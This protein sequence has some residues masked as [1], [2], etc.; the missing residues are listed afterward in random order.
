ML[1]TS[2]N[3]LF[4][5]LCSSCFILALLSTALNTALPSIA[6]DLGVNNQSVQWLISIYAL[7]LA[8]FMPAT[9]YFVSRFTAR[10]LYAASLILFLLCTL[11]CAF[12]SSFELLLVA[13]IGQAAANALVSNLTQTTILSVFN[14]EEQ[15]SRMGW[16]GLSVGVAP[17]IAPAFGG[18]MVDLFGWR[19]LFLVIAAGAALCLLSSFFFMQNTIDVELAS[20]DIPSFVLSVFVFGGL[21]L[22]LSRLSAGEFLALSSLMPLLCALLAAVCFI[23]CQLC[24]SKPFLNL[25]LFRNQYFTRSVIASSALYAVMM[26]GAAVLPLYLQGDLQWSA[27]LA[28]FVVFPAA[29]AMALVNP[30]A[31]KM[32]NR[33]GIRKLACLSCVFMFAGNILMC[34]L[35]FSSSVP[36]VILLAIF[37]YLGI[38][39]LQMPLV[40]W[41]NSLL[42]K[43]ELPHATAL[44]T[45]F[46]NLFG[47]LG[48]AVFVGIFNSAGLTVG[49]TAMA[50]V[51]LFV[52]I[53]NDN[54]RAEE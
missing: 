31:G 47:A 5:L 41:A 2:K 32:L 34:I 9:A 25:A 38:G 11:L 7:S 21:T 17:V 19:S 22:G 33:L 40:V 27:T 39:L 52:L 14:K 50:F 10:I 35:S 3:A 8:V 26:G 53:A 24:A 23:P 29:L 51:A 42:N 13:R 4:L 1:D 16:F 43:S 28:G 30:F 12:S 54:K 15:G 44:L 36:A 6:F 18:V 46:R 20:F 37:R 48:V 45:S 49:F